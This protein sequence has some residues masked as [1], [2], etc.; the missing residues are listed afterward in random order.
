MTF[1]EFWALFPRRQAKADARKAWQRLNPDA[2][3]CAKIEIALGWQV[4]SEDWRKDDGRYVP[5]PASWLRGERWDD[6]A[7]E[8]RSGHD[9]RVSPRGY[10]L[11]CPHTPRCQ[12]TWDCCRRQELERSA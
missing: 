4:E 12:K 2:E 5:L 11:E 9:R 7:L 8:R 10:A 1:E 6:E 3:L